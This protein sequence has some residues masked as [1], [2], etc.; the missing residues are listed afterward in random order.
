MSPRGRGLQAALI[1]LVLAL[2]A[3]CADWGDDPA[4]PVDPPDPPDPPEPPPGVSF[5]ADVQP[6]FDASCV[7]CHGVGGN[8][9]L[10][11]RQGA[12][13]ANL[14]GAAATGS[15]LLRVQPGDPA[16]SWLYLKLTGAQ[17]AGTEMPPGSPLPAAQIDHVRVWIEEGAREN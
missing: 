7:G 16:A 6:I 5:A 3:G 14:V 17:D 4:G 1:G 8:G 2:G 11:L 9:G 15:S 13:H 10:D 12:S